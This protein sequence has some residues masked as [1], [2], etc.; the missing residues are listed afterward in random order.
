MTMTLVVGGRLVRRIAVPFGLGILMLVVVLPY[1]GAQAPPK[2]ITIGESNAPYQVAELLTYFGAQADEP[3]VPVTLEDTQ[4]AMEGIF[5]TSAITSAYSSTAL[6]CRPPGAGL[7]V[8]TR[9]IT[10]VTPG[11]YAM[12]LAAAGIDDATLAVAAPDDAPAEGMTA[13]TGVFATWETGPCPS[14]ATD[15][16][17]QRLALEELALTVDI[18]LGLGTADGVRTAADLVLGIHRD[19]VVGRYTDRSAIDA[20]VAQHATAIGADL[21]A[22]Q[23]DRLVDLM[24]RLASTQIDWGTFA[25]G[26]KVEQSPDASRIAMTGMNVGGPA[27][28]ASDPT[29]TV[30]IQA[31]SQAAALSATAPAPTSTPIPSPTPTPVPFTVR[32]TVVD[33]RGEHLDVG[34]EDGGAPVAFTIDA[35]VPVERAGK[36]ATAAQ[37]A[38]NDRVTMTVESGA[39]RE[40]MTIAAEP[41]PANLRSRLADLWPVLLA[42]LLIL[43]AAGAALRRKGVVLAHL[44]RPAGPSVV[45]TVV[46]PRVHSARVVH[47]VIRLRPQTRIDRSDEAP[48]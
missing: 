23:R 26:W 6:T 24:T 44:A 40:V 16:T 46:R 25:A 42:G 5:D 15:A 8:T 18:G 36:P 29:T 43:V 35:S 4:R 38:K 7:E 1:T 19:I 20:V 33:I 13:L 47:R 27:S 28:V 3:F 11:L 17:R 48:T 31:T 10:V 21:P 30:D 9:N 34:L 14:G 41:E 2:T 32:G 12:A 39:G 37:I 45:P 22:T